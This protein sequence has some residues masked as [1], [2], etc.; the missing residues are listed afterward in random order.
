MDS[1][2]IFSALGA[3]LVDHERKMT[4][5]LDLALRALA[6]DWSDELDRRLGELPAPRDGEPG[7]DGL[8]RVLALPRHI[9]PAE[10]YERN[11]IAWWRAGIWQA[12][13]AGQGDPETDPGGWKCLVPGIAAIETREDW[14]KRELVFAFVLASGERHETRARMLPGF[15]PPDWQ[16]SGIGVLAG[17][18]MREGDFERLAL[19]DGADPA[20]ASDWQAREI[21]GRRGRDGKGLPGERGPAGPG[22]VGLTFAREPGGPLVILPQY[23]DPTVKAA[24]VEVELFL[25]ELA[26]PLR[27]ILGFE[28]RHSATKAYRRGSVVSAPG[29]ALW[30]SLAPDN[31]APLA[32]GEQWERMI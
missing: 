4:A 22:L 31:R 19:V 23:A 30:L 18:I 3:A 12:V 29:G 21:R 20:K 9:G 6:D 24:P 1:E 5:E 2:A 7:K 16:A 11:D 26:P 13:R 25:G 17:D 8:D 27:P 28:G 32:E 15:L 10:R 14:R